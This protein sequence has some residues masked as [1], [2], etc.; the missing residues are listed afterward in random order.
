ML[1]RCHAKHEL[2]GDAVDVGGGADQ[3]AAR[4]NRQALVCLQHLALWIRKAISFVRRVSAIV[5]LLEPPQSPHP[6]PGVQL[7]GGNR[8]IRITVPPLARGVTPVIAWSRK[9]R[10]P[11]LRLLPTDP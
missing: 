8:Q 9:R 6:S 11:P 4:G 5:G 10:I 1:C 7:T 2:L 3:Q